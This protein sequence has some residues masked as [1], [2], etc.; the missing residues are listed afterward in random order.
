MNLKFLHALVNEC[1]LEMVTFNWLP[2]EGKDKYASI[3]DG[4]QNDH[5][6]D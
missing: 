6:L 1:T 5:G 4:K 3:S 2:W